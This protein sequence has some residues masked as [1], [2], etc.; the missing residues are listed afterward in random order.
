MCD[1]CRVNPATHSFDCITEVSGVHIFYT[2]FQNL[3]DYSNFANVRKHIELE[4]ARV[5]SRPWAWIIDCKYLESKHMFQLNFAISIIKYLRKTHTQ[6]LVN[7][8]LLNG[9]LLMSTGLHAMSPFIDQTF[10]NSILLFHGTRLELLHQFQARGW[11]IRDVE[12]LMS[13]LAREY[14]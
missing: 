12:P 1:L 2:S 9:G 6:S 7:I 5:S 10:Y 3:L 8:Y 11:S 14:Y 4:L 13:R